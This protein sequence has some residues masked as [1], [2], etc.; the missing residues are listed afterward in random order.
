MIHNKPISNTPTSYT[1]AVC[2][3]VLRPKPGQVEVVV[4]H[5]GGVV[6]CEDHRDALPKQVAA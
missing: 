2:G 4:I 1:C 6:T 5:P 3:E